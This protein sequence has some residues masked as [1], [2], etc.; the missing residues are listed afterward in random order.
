MARLKKSSNNGW[1]LWSKPHQL[2]SRWG[3]RALWGIVWW[4]L[5][6][7]VITSVIVRLYSDRPF[8]GTELLLEA[9]LA[10]LGGAAFGVIFCAFFARFGP[11]PHNSKSPE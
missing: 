3:A 2:P 1:R 7:F 4:G 9:L 8:I 6:F 11:S 5:S 10:L